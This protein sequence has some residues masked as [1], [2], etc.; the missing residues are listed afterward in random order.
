MP[1]NGFN[2]TNKILNIKIM[3]NLDIKSKVAIGGLK[4]I[5]LPL[6]L[7]RTRNYFRNLRGNQWEEDINLKVMK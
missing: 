1:H 6:V 4:L 5:G 2:C 3:K 7:E